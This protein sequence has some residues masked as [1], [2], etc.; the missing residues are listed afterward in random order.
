M[1]PE[2]YVMILLCYALGCYASFR[3]GRN[4]GLEEGVAKLVSYLARREGKTTKQIAETIL[5]RKL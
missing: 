1:A 5:G 3:L 2:T 4:R